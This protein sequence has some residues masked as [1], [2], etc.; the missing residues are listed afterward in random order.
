MFSD[1]R[2]IVEA[3]ESRNTAAAEAAISDH[4]ERGRE[5]AVRYLEALAAPET[6]RA[7]V[8]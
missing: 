7:A 5:R 3:I 2:A 8:R 6:K 1:H 4:L